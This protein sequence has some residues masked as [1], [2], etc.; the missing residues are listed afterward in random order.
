MKKLFTQGLQNA[1]AVK[2][3]YVQAVDIIDPLLERLIA[4]GVL[5]QARFLLGYL[6][7]NPEIKILGKGYGYAKYYTEPAGH[8]YALWSNR[9]NGRISDKSKAQCITCKSAQF[10]NDVQGYTDAKGN[11]VAAQ[12]AWTDPFMETIAKYI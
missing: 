11:K 3:N 10:L 8:T 12:I 9:T 1:L 4:D 2:I 7:V 5:H 6:E